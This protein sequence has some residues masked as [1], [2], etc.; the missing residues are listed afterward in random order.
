MS[1]AIKCSLTQQIFVRVSSI[2]EAKHGL[3]NKCHSEY[4]V[5]FLRSSDVCLSL[6]S[7]TSARFEPKVFA[8]SSLMKWQKR[9]RTEL[10]EIEKLIKSRQIGKEAKDVRSK[11]GQ[12]ANPGWD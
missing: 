2:K 5:S 6:P 11:G 8:E 12:M 4:R 7:P 9:D 10:I 1:P 3:G